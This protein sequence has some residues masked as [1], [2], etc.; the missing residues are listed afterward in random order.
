MLLC[1]LPMIKNRY[2]FN[3]GDNGINFYSLFTPMCT[4]TPTTTPFKTYSHIFLNPGSILDVWGRRYVL[5]GADRYVL[6][7]VRQHAEEISPKVL[8]SLA[9]F[10]GEDEKHEPQIAA[11]E[12]Q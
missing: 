11:E 10:F 4:Y 1:V 6:S 3:L 8:S 2:I 9:T 7:Y 12:N 5:T